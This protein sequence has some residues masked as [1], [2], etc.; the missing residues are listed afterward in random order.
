[1]GLLFGHCLHIENCFSHS[2]DGF[3]MGRKVCVLDL[4]YQRKAVEFLV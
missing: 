3:E 1:M 2:E 4:H